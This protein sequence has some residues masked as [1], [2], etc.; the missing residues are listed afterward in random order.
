MY[1]LIRALETWSTTCGPK[2]PQGPKQIKQTKC[3]H[4]GFLFREG[5]L[6][7]PHG[8]VRDLLVIEVH[9]GGLMG[10]FGVAKTL[11]MLQEQFF[12]P[13]MKRDVERVYDRCMACKKAKLRIKP[14]RLYT[15]LPIPDEPWVD[16][17]MDFV[18]SLPRTK[19]EKNSIFVVFDRLSKM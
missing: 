1:A 18:L 7:I 3:Q 17:S 8:S 4:D 14:H 10:H 19:I 15:P 5:K 9:S 13:R 11:A 2:T 12:W 16:N 6:W